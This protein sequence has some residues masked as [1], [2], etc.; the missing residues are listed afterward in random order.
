M[1]EISEEKLKAIIESQGKWLGIGEKR[2]SLK[3]PWRCTND[4]VE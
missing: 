3:M 4:D 2:K 1:K